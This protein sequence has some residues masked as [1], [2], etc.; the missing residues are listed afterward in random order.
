MQSD[1]TIKIIPLVL[2]I[3][4]FPTPFLFIFN[5]LHLSLN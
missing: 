1:V 5:I 4:F 2:R 3:I